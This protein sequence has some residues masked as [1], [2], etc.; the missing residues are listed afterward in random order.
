MARV[1][2]F[3]S[4][5]RCIRF[6]EVLILQGGP[7]IGLA[8]SI[9]NITP[10]RLG[11]T[12]LFAGAS[13]LLVAHIFFFNDWAEVAQQDGYPSSAVAPVRCRN[14][15][16]NAL[17][18]FSILLLAASLLLFLLFPLPTLLLA[19]AIAA[20]GILY[21]HPRHNGKSRPIISSLIHFGGGML[22]FLLGYSVFSEIDQRGLLIGLFFALSFAAGHLNQE[23]RDY[24]L[25]RQ[26]GARTNAVAFGKKRNFLAGI[27]LFAFSYA[28]LSLLCWCGFL[29]R[30]LAFLPLVLF[31]LHFLW[32]MRALRSDLNSASIRRLQ[33]QYRFLYALIGLSMMATLFWR[34]LGWPK[35]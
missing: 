34:Q 16:P 1:S 25:D 10:A 15:T 31:P 9:G 23:V 21:S 8:F 27:V 7:L 29:P 22:H 17:F 3:L 14:V 26:V 28:Y 11:T 5:V 13:F 20:L 35:A 19:A 30:L 12:I 33:S 6:G 18:W 4:L 32:S 24:N 2:Q